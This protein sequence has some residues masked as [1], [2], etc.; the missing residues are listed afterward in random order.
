MTR[1]RRIV[2][3]GR[4]RQHRSIV[5]SKQV[6]GWYVATI[7]SLA[8]RAR[9]T[10]GAMSKTLR[11]L[12][13]IGEIEVIRVAGGQMKIRLLKDFVMPVEEIVEVNEP[14]SDSLAKVLFC[15]KCGILILDNRFVQR[16]ECKLWTSQG[17]NGFHDWRQPNAEGSRPVSVVPVVPE[18]LKRL[19]AW[20]VS[21]GVPTSKIAE[22]E[23]GG[24]K[25]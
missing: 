16:S 17:G 3:V 12:A 6:D 9:V 2:D 11:D 10:R 25:R 21:I 8:A 24:H 13:A 4:E 23:K 1:T 19:R 22:I 7:A 20:A 18:E 5:T 15:V 14:S